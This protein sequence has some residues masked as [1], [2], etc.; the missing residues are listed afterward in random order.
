M[1]SMFL[2]NHFFAPELLTSETLHGLCDRWG[3]LSIALQR[4]VFFSYQ[5]IMQQRDSSVN[6]SGEAG[7]LCLRVMSG[8]VRCG[9]FNR[10]DS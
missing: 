2:P 6:S 5:N 3:F 1:A 9:L 7:S 8:A 4:A 10:Y